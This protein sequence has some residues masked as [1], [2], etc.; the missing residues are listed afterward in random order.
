M[1]KNPKLPITIQVTQYSQILN[2]S[3]PTVYTILKDEIILNQILK[4]E[5]EFADKIRKITKDHKINWTGYK[6]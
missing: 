3:R 4:A 2:K 1:L 6:K 5:S